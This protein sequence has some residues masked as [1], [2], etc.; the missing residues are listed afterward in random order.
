MGA[1]A[2]ACHGLP[3][4]PIGAL[5]LTIGC[6]LNARGRNAHRRYQS[7]QNAHD[8]A[9]RESVMH[10]ARSFL[11]LLAFAICP[12]LLAPPAA[13]DKYP[14]RP[15]HWVVGFAAGGPN[16]IVARVLGEWLSAHLGQQ[17]VIEN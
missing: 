13:A 16:D 2:P 15:V 7:R 6:G 11:L 12:S 9:S 3:T 4:I 1:T 17:F 8:D 14:S 5:S 10:A